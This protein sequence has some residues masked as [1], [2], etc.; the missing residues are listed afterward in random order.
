MKMP[1][2]IKAGISILWEVNWTVLSLFF[3]GGGGGGESWMVLFLW[4]KLKYYGE[5]IRGGGGGSSLVCGG[6]FPCYLD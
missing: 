3:G 2:S 4:G 5:G 1:A 6:S